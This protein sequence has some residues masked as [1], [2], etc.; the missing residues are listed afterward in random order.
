MYN[1]SNYLVAFKKTIESL[2][3]ARIQKNG[4]THFVS[5]IVTSVNVDGSINVYLPPDTTNIISNLL[6]KTGEVLSA[7]DSVELCS[8]NGKIN[9]SWVALKHGTNVQGGGGGLRGA[10]FRYKGTWSSTSQYYNTEDYIDV[11]EYNGSSYACILTNT[12]NIPSSSPTYWGLMVSKGNTGSQGAKGVSFR[13]LG[14][15]NSSTAYINDTQY[16]DV[17]TYD[18]SSYACLVGNTNQTPPNATYWSLIANKGNTGA[19][20]IQGNTGA[21]GATGTSLRNKGAWSSST[22]YVNNSTYIDLITYNG[23]FYACKVSNTNQTPT[24]TTY[25]DLLV[26]KGET[27]DTGIQGP[28]GV[29]YSSTQPTTNDV[30]WV[31]P[32][33]DT[34]SYYK[35]TQSEAEA[36]IDN[37]N[38]MTPLRVAQAINSLA[39]TNNSSNKVA[40]SLETTQPEPIV[41]TAILWVD[42]S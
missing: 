22:A 8:K 19:Q 20:G 36:G 42:I 3:D 5:A 27:G 35:A 1:D 15:W 21:T 11:V 16:I 30:I 37:S 32:D 6:N 9:N 28:S 25:W 33:E 14:V 10:S 7:G 23:S 18:G 17:V 12:S 34:E 26:S 41:G 13:N 40:I 2:V 4:I 24:N 39:I 38:Y 31:D 29:V